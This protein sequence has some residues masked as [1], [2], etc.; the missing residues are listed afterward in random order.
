MNKIFLI[1]N[2]LL[3]LRSKARLKWFILISIVRFNNIRLKRII[4]QSDYFNFFE[5]NCFFKN[6]KS[7]NQ[8]LFFFF[9]QY[10]FQFFFLIFKSL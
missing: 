3:N 9:F 7:K 2:I 6:V 8:K 10:F 4:K 5:A 1:S